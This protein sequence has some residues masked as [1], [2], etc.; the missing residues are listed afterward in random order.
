MP[1]STWRLRD[2]LNTGVL[3]YETPF[4]DI[5]VTV[6]EVAEEIEHTESEIESSAVRMACH[7]KEP[8]HSG[9]E[10]HSRK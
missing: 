6:E 5:D 10:N 2:H 4:I 8:S 7:R 3:C 1:L 9:L